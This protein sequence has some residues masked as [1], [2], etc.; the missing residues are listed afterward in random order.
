MP[1]IIV[2]APQDALGAPA[3]R[4]IVEELTGFA[5]DCEKLPRSPF[6]QSTVWTYFNTYAPDA[7]YMGESPANLPI[8]SVQIYTIAGGLAADAKKRLIS[9]ATDIIGK[10]LTKGDR[11]PVYVVIHE[12]DAANWGIFGSNPD[13]A[14]MRGAPLDAPAL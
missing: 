5:L 4:A 6:M 3:R 1:K 9:G 2:H 14:A 7:V 11:P 8:V 10:H 13:L 12:I